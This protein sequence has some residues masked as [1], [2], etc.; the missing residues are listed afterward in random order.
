MWGVDKENTVNVDT[1]YCMKP[2][3]LDVIRSNGRKMLFVVAGGNYL[4]EDGQP[5]GADPSPGLLGLI[6]LT[7]NGA[8]L[9]VVGTNG[10]YEGYE[11]YGGYPQHDTV[12]IHKLGPNGTYGW[13]ARLGYAHS[14]REH[15]W[16]QMYGL[17]SNSV[18]LL[19]V[20][21][22]QFSEDYGEEICQEVGGCS[23][24]SAKYTFDTHSSASSF[25]PLILQVS[26]IQKGRPFRG[27]YRLVFD[28][29]LLKYLRPENVP[30]EIMPRV[31]RTSESV[32]HDRPCDLAQDHP[33][34]FTK[35]WNPAGGNAIMFGGCGETVDT[36]GEEFPGRARWWGAV[37]CGY[38][39]Y[40]EN[41]KRDANP[42][43]NEHL[44]EGWGRGWDEAAKA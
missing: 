33:E 38:F 39:A 28:D 32:R 41:K 21:V 11:N 24:L 22:T 8:K 14:N 19:T 35:I 36:P 37:S 12:T 34:K 44:K 20:F 42:Y 25:Y 29:K 1:T 3:R 10:L 30:D 9:G 23:T 26:G 16:V 6:V 2:I 18:K 43:S 13:V 40:R 15:E 27:N 5:Q 4:D 7:P 17:I 31:E